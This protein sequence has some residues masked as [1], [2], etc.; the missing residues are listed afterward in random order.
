MQRAAAGRA[1]AR[2]HRVPRGGAARAVAARGARRAD[3]CGRH[4]Q[5]RR[6]RG[7]QGPR[8]LR[9]AP[10]GGGVVRGVRGAVGGGAAARA[11]DPRRREQELAG[12]HGAVDAEDDGPRQQPHADRDR[13][14][15]RLVQRGRLGVQHP[16]DRPL[17]TRTSRRASR[18]PSASRA[19]RRRGT[20][21]TARSGSP[22]TRAAATWPTSSAAAS[23]SSRSRSTR[24]RGG[25]S[26]STRTRRSS[27]CSLRSA[28]LISLLETFPTRG[29]RCASACRRT[30]TS[31]SSSCPSRSPPSGS[32]SPTGRASCRAPVAVL[33]K[34]LG[35]VGWICGMLFYLMWMHSVLR[36]TKH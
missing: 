5:P 29:G 16:A 30:R 7:A 9:R 14:V 4:A 22:A 2:R 15:P 25:S 23:G 1:A 34:W 18:T 27:R 21:S 10:G 33:L 20:R 11:G 13:R 32:P 26:S 3:V 28:D 31:A 8:P 12:G 17:A 24:R 19:R 6:P 35:V 36:F